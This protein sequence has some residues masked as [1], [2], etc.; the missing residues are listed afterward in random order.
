MFSEKKSYMRSIFS[1]FRY[2]L[3]LLKL[4]AMAMYYNEGYNEQENFHI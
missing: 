2:L 4:V 3:K 1:W